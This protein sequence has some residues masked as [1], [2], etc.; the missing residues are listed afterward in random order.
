MQY[1]VVESYFLWKDYR[2]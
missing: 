2:S 1:M